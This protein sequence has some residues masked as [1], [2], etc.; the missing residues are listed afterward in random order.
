MKNKPVCHR[1]SCQQRDIVC[2]GRS[3]P[4]EWNIRSEK[5]DT[6]KIWKI[7]NGTLRNLKL[8]GNQMPVSILEQ[9]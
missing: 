3:W 7:M 8:T 1:K 4:K 5:E 2:W 6:I 9:V